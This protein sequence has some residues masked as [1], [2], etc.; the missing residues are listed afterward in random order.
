LSSKDLID[1]GWFLMIILF[2][3]KNNVVV[4]SSRPCPNTRV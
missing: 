4:S 2:L 1:Q 3:I